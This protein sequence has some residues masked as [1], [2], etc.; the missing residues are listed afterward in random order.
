VK[1]L[2]Y[3]AE[4]AAKYKLSK[5]AFTTIGVLY[6]KKISEKNG[7]KNLGYIPGV[8]NANKAAYEL[9]ASIAFWF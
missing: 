4:T 5:T 1:T 7:I 2:S 3:K 8:Y 6:E 9:I